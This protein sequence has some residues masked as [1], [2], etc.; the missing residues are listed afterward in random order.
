M[1]LFPCSIEK[2]TYNPE[3]DNVVTSRW[4][5]CRV[6]LFPS[7]TRIRLERPWRPHTTLTGA[8]HLTS[9]I[10][11]NLIYFVLWL[12]DQI[13]ATTFLAVK[14]TDL[15]FFLMEG[16][17][18]WASFCDIFFN[19][20]LAFR[21]CIFAWAIACVRIFWSQTQHLVSRKHLLDSLAQIVFSH[22]LSTSL[23]PLKKM[24]RPSE[25]GL[26]CRRRLFGV[27]LRDYP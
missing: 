4:I 7:I 13:R 1:L 11:G 15:I 22:F 10:W 23:P 16:G 12:R 8:R 14:G 17:G 5:V 20:F 2:Q 25:V 9:C 27:K 6:R 19:F 26:T 24:V 21:S 3:G 18:G